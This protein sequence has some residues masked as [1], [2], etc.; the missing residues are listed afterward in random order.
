[1]QAFGLIIF[2][3]FETFPLHF[4]MCTYDNILMAV[5]TVFSHLYFTEI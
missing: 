2:Q 5:F 3:T 1:M 4:T